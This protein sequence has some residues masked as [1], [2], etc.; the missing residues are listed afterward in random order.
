MVVATADGGIGAFTKRDYHRRVNVAASRA[1]D[2]LFVFHSVQ[3]AELHADDARAMLLSYVTR[4]AP[5]APPLDG[6]PMLE[7]DFTREVWRR[8]TAAGLHPVPRFRLG[9]YQIDFVVN[10]PDGRRLAIACDDRYRG[11]SAFAAELRRQAILERV[12]NCVF[13]RLRASLFHRDPDRA[14]RP[15]WSRASELGLLAPEPMGLG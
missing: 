6:D 15:I 10:A 11:A 2:Q 9:A 8:L 4:P 5:A 14:M 3:P 13:V 1:R 7:T 12:G